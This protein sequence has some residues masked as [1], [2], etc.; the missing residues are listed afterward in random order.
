MQNETNV[1]KWNQQP[2][3]AIKGLFCIYVGAHVLAWL[4]IKWFSAF[5]VSPEKM[6][7]FDV[8]SYQLLA[9]WW[10][11][12]F[13]AV[14]N[15][16]F[17]KIK[18]RI[19]QGV[20]GLILCAILGYLTFAG[21]YWIGL[22]TDWVFPIMAN[23]YFF[24]VFFNFTGENWPFGNYSIPEKFFLLLLINFGGT[25]FITHSIIWIIPA[26]WFPFTQM[27]FPNQ[28]GPYL[29]RKMEQPGKTIMWWSFKWILVGF[30]LYFAWLAGVLDTETTLAP[31]WK[32]ANFKPEFLMWIAVGS[33]YVFGITIPTQNWPWRYIRMPWGGFLSLLFSCF[34]VT[35]VAKIYI[36]LVGVIFGDIWIAITYA[37]MTAPLT[38]IVT[39][40]F[41]VGFETTYL[42]VGQKTPGSWEDID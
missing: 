16:P 25:W 18:G 33:G 11:F 37:W 40:L 38:F 8:S 2:Y 14:G 21:I 24:V 7:W 19:A 15:W 13:A 4:L 29:F 6:L 22:N 12:A 9:L 41:G 5:P 28:L 31:F 36:G 30:L 3:I 35:L 17:N 20:V 1:S 23:L 39:F 42:W 27:T 26:W 10:I 34:L 32:I